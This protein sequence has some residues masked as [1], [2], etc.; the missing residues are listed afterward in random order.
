MLSAR[1][2]N[3]TTVAKSRQVLSWKTTPAMFRYF[4]T[5]ATTKDPAGKILDGTAKI[6]DLSTHDLKAALE[7]RKI[8]YKDCLDD[9]D[10]SLRKRLA[11]CLA[12]EQAE[13]WKKKCWD[14]E[15]ILT[16]EESQ[17]L[18]PATT[19][20]LSKGLTGLDQEVL[21]IVPLW[22]CERASIEMEKN[23]GP[24]KDVAFAQ[25]DVLQNYF[26]QNPVD[27]GIGDVRPVIGMAAATIYLHDRNNDGASGV[28]EM[29]EADLRSCHERTIRYITRIPKNWFMPLPQ[30]L[31][32]KNILH[33]PYCLMSAFGKRL[34]NA[35]P[36]STLKSTARS[37]SSLFKTVE[38]YELLLLLYNNM[39]RMYLV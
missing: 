8:S 4:A 38:C 16:L 37:L 30:E 34:G 35:K 25:R 15:E 26:K 2:A 23:G 33:M 22:D 1:R 10:D 18:L 17:H 32:P 27:W 11:G 24:N 39:Y 28:R 31:G 20:V 7:Y 13:L 12:Q 19:L 6:N 5:K 21:V 14:V 3:A 9:G 36:L 29:N